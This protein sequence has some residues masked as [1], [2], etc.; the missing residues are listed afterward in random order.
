MN[1]FILEKN[2]GT[3][4]Y[5]LTVLDLRK[6]YPA[7]SI[8][9][10]L[11]TPEAVGEGLLPVYTTTG[12][13]LST[14]IAGSINIP[15]VSPIK[16]NGKWEVEPSLL[17]TPP[18]DTGEVEV[19]TEPVLT[20]QQLKT[21]RLRELSLYTDNLV[22]GIAT[23]QNIPLAEMQT[24]SIQMAEALAWERDPDVETPMLDTIARARG[25]SRTY[26][27]PK[28]VAKSKLY[29]QLLAHIVGSR[30][31]IEDRIGRA[32]SEEEVRNVY[33]QITLPDELM[34]LDSFVIESPHVRK[35]VW[36]LITNK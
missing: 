34:G 28:A 4:V 36:G 25:V 10:T 20:L 26:L 6:M 31:A 3:V 15:K 21:L 7:R 33:I 35:K 18:T 19:P 29:N 30:Q 2:D 9:L 13:F 11:S 32:N 23:T 22:N 8:P 12:K 1:I 5:P 16:R 27:I 17:Y 14:L 24:W